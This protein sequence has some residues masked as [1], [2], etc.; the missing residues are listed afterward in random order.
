MKQKRAMAL[1][2]KE[3]EESAAKVSVQIPSVLEV[4]KE[5]QETPDMSI[6]NHRVKDVVFILADFKN[7]KEENRSRSEY[8]SILHKDLAMYYSY[9]EF[10]IEKL[11]ELFP[12]SELIE[13]LEANEAPR[14]VTIRTNT[15]KTRRKQLAQA[16]I[17][18]G[19]NLDMINWSKVGLVVFDTPGGVTLG[20]TSEYLAGYYILQGASSFLPVMALGP[21]E[22]EKVLDMCAAPG[23]KST[24]I[25][26]L[27]RNTG[28]LVANDVNPDRVKAL[29]GNFHRM[30]ITNTVISSLDGRKFPKMMP[31]GFNRVLLDA[32]CSGTGVI[33]KDERVKT[34]KE[35]R[36]I[37]QCAML[38]KELILAAVDS[39]D[40]QGPNGGYICYS[41]CSI[42][43]E[44]NEA[45]VD[46]VLKKRDVKL[47]PTGLDVGKAGYTKF[48]QHRFHPSLNLCKRIYPHVNNMD[49]FFVAKL[50]K[51]SNTSPNKEKESETKEKVLKNKN[52]KEKEENESGIEVD[53]EMD[54]EQEETAVTEEK[55]IDSEIDAEKSEDEEEVEE[56]PKNNKSPKNEKNSK[57]KPKNKVSKYKTNHNL[58]KWKNSKKQKALN[59]T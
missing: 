29:F 1:G 37:Q 25:A 57:N 47:I 20:A 16:M 56:S 45:V 18:R 52:Q 3:L 32:P 43:V 34:S 10:M 36:D 6:I 27:M 13:F 44:E 42:M 46:Y 11:M 55:E 49:G 30:G 14:P 24:H 21:K 59:K 8:L 19:I 4:E 39:V 5:L 53:E 7:R 38:Q 28:M 31:C 23:G 12:P 9:N 26:A 22:N 2:Q 51:L 41:T 54:E 17:N 58:C 50:K 15:L 35:Y 33:S 48:R 40:A